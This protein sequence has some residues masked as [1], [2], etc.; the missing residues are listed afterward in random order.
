MR[1]NFVSYPKALCLN[2]PLGILHFYFFTFLKS[3]V[4]TPQ[5]VLEFIQRSPSKL[6]GGIYLCK[7]SW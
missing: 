2:L 5:K 7:I 1:R 6:F 3:R 4:N